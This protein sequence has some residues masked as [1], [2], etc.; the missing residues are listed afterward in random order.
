VDEPELGVAPRQCTSSLVVP[1]EQFSGEK[2][3]QNLVWYDIYI[4]PQLGW[5]PVAAVHHTL[6]HKQ[7]TYTQTIHVHT[8]STHNTEIGKFGSASRA[9]SCELYPGICL[10]AEEKHGKTSVRVANEQ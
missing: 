7:Y 1:C 8:N 2:L 4:L 5:H 10:T 9:P 6:T 3:M